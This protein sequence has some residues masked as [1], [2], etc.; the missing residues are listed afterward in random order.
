[1]HEHARD[2]H[3]ST[4]H[5]RTRITYRPKCTARHTHIIHHAL[6]HT[7][8]YSIARTDAHITHTYTRTHFSPFVT[9]FGRL[10][11]N[12]FGVIVLF[13]SSFFL[14]AFYLFSGHLLLFVADVCVC[15]RLVVC[16]FLSVFLCW[17][18]CVFVGLCVWVWL[19]V[20]YFVHSS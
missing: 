2:T 20:C 12:G 5:D 10:S 18:V 19:F 7:R 6:A 8:T 13:I 16:S 4:Q 17:F 11:A 15:V 9:S 14:L 3:A 1:M